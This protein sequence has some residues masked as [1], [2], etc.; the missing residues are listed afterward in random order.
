M[1]WT[2]GGCEAGAESQGPLGNMSL[3]LLE[4]AV[5]AALGHME[6][7]E[8]YLAACQEEVFRGSIEKALLR[9]K[10]EVITEEVRGMRDRVD[11][12]KSEA[13]M[14]DRARTSTVSEQRRYSYG[15]KKAPSDCSARRRRID[16]GDSGF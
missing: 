7:A 2:S 4:Q 8:E 11:R 12:I 16:S 6:A 9:Q 14:H 5:V 13:E 3:R 10:V 15:W 1:S